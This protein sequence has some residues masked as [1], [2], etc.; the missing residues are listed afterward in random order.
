[1]SRMELK[2]NTTEEL[3]RTLRNFAELTVKASNNWENYEAIVLDILKQL[4]LHYK[5]NVGKSL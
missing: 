2:V 5:N 4:E 3:A 1:M